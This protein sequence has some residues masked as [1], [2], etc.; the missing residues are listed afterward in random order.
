MKAKKGNWL[1]LAEWIFNDKEYEWE[2]KCV[3]TKKV[4]GKKIKED[5][6]YQ[7]IDGNF[8]EVEDE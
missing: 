5:T 1:V 7:L 2:V 3:K 4:D 6:L 8:V